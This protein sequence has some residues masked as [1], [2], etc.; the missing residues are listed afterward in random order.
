MLMPP[1]FGAGAVPAVCRTCARPVDGDRVSGVTPPW[2]RSAL[3][4]LGGAA[5]WLRAA[6][7]GG[8][9]T[10]SWLRGA[11][12]TRPQSGRRR[13]WRRP[14]WREGLLHPRGDAGGVVAPAG[15][16]GVAA[17]AARAA[18]DEPVDLLCGDEGL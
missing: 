5:S 6:V 11:V 18:A 9:T 16:G 2:L 1:R 3:P 17:A 14:L 12:M 15:V 13:W 4:T 10:A 8:L 7:T